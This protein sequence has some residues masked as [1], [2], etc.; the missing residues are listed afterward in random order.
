MGFITMKTLTQSTFHTEHQKYKNPR[1]P[2]PLRSHSDYRSPTHGWPH[3]RE[4]SFRRNFATKEPFHYH[5][6]AGKVSVV[7]D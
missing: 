7:D 3:D 6:R 5:W 2:P 1:Y 4:K